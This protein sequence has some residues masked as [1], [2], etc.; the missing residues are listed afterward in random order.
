MRASTHQIWLSE[1]K[2]RKR[3]MVEAAIEFAVNG[4]AMQDENSK[5]KN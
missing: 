2:V 4:T 1:M 3:K 5:G